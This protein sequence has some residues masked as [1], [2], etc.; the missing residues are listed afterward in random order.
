MIY[1]RLIKYF[2][3]QTIK[4]E[5]HLYYLKFNFYNNYIILKEILKKFVKVWLN[6][7]INLIENFKY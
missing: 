7:K 2:M 6:L 3:E 4:L 1:L 5:R